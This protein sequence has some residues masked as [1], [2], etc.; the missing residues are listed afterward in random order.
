MKLALYEGKGAFWNKVINRKYGE[1]DGAWRSHKV[2]DGHEVG[3]WKAIRK[4]WDIL[5]R[6]VAYSIGALLYEKD[7][8]KLAQVFLG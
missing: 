8:L 4:D 1:E 6:K 3:L 5:S 7:A 2:K